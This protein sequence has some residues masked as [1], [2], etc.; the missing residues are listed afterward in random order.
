VLTFGPLSNYMDA[1][2][3]IYALQGLGLYDKSKLLTSIEEIAAYYI[4]EILE[5]DPH[6]PYAL[7]GYSSG[8]ILAYE[9]ARQLLEIGKEV[10]LLALLDTGTD[11]CKV[12]ST[13]LSDEIK[14]IS[15][16]I[17]KAAFYVVSLLKRPRETIRYLKTKVVKSRES[18]DLI[19]INN[20]YKRAFAKYRIQ[21]LDI[22]I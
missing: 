1:Q 8:G 16:L 2:Q 4:S 19:E 18:E 6:G 13:A 9:M 7:G 22:K 10:S 21:P 14:K 17:K 12:D 15:Y 5:N 3:P 20:R 11:I